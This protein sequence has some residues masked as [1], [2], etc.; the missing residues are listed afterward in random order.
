[1]DEVHGLE[2]KLGI[3]PEKRWVPS[4]EEWAAA[5]EKVRLRNY[6]KRLDHLEALVV[7]RIFELSKMNMPQIGE[8][9]LT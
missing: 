5:A 1:M 2:L 9:N 8:Y 3:S 6:R 4:S 7:A